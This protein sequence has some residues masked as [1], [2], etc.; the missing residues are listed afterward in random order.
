MLLHYG[1]NKHAHTFALFV[2]PWLFLRNIYIYIYI[3]FTIHTIRIPVGRTTIQICFLSHFSS[4]S[5][6]LNILGL[7]KPV[8]Y[9][10]LFFSYFLIKLQGLF[11]SVNCLS[12]LYLYIYFW[13]LQWR[14]SSL[15]CLRSHSA[16]LI[17]FFSVFSLFSSER[18]ICFAR[19]VCNH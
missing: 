12:F 16:P 9:P 4:P 14:Y 13:S 11:T 10:F 7:S 6:C 19:S 5:L 1:L 3:G 8:I 2:S 18:C 15:P 17:F